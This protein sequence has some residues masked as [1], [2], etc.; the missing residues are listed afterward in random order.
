[1]R[2][3]A[4]VL[5]CLLTVTAVSGCDATQ[6]EDASMPVDAVE[7]PGDL[8]A[9]VPASAVTR[10]RLTADGH[11]TEP[12]G[13]RS[14]ARCSMS[15]RVDGAPVSLEVTLTS[16][17]ASDLA[18]LQQ[19]L[20]DELAALCAALE[21]E[22]EGDGEYTDTDRRCSS[23][24]RTRVTEVSLSTPSQGVLVVSMAHDGPQR[25]LLGAEVV[26][27]SGSIANG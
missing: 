21:A 7:L 5:A 2:Q 6:P 18:D 25:Q 3:S 4:A 24:Q 11:A 12:G 1:M 9:V 16:Y 15:G 23:E 10:W 27:I 22:A 20:A 17:G 13:D 8:C 14:E 26:G 19:T